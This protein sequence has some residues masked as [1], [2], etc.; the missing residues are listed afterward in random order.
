VDGQLTGVPDGS[1]SDAGAGGE[2]ESPTVQTDAELLLEAVARPAAFEA[3]FARHAVTIHRYVARRVDP[4]VVE[5]LVA[6]TFAIAFDRRASYRREYPDARPWL[7]G[8][9]THLMARHRRSE[10]TR[11]RAFARADRVETTEAV[12]S[13]AIARADAR[14]MSG[15]LATALGKLRDGD[16]DAIL[17]LAWGDLGYE[18]IA[19]ALDIPVGTVRSRINRARRRLR[20]LLPSVVAINPQEPT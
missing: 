14:A 7:F 10:R 18:E 8:I 16:R 17:L 9:A 1:R 6:E 5:D 19:R 20:E 13:A 2:R 3:I 12:D 4:S 11:L 15:E